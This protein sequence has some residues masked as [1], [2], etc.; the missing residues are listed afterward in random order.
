[1]LAPANA[2]IIGCA[3]HAGAANTRPVIT[4]FP[5]IVTDAA[6]TGIMAVPGKS[7]H[8][9]GSAADWRLAVA[10]AGVGCARI[11]GEDYPVSF[12]GLID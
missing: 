8:L 7:N 10:R 4:S 11:G 1:M 9:T 6:E 3:A 5:V 2:V 12:P